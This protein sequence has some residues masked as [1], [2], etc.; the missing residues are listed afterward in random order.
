MLETEV[1]ARTRRVSACAPRKRRHKSVPGGRSVPSFR[2][3]PFLKQK[4]PNFIPR[5][6]HITT[7]QS[8]MH[9]F[10]TGAAAVHERRQQPR[11]GSS[12]RREEDALFRTPCCSRINASVG[13]LLTTENFSVPSQML[14]K[15]CFAGGCCAGLSAPFCF[16]AVAGMMSHIW[17]VP[18]TS[19]IAHGINSHLCDP[20]STHAARRISTCTRAMSMP[21]SMAAV[22]GL[23]EELYALVHVARAHVLGSYPCMPVPRL[24]DGPLVLR[25]CCKQ[26]T[27]HHWRG[28]VG[29]HGF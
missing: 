11:S 16:L 14:Y 25:S 8:H 18:S 2:G 6:A 27:C 20:P 19:P 21:L 4:G 9:Y 12:P 7:S 15:L 3:H 1:G 13:Y 29:P 24:P 10:C 22:D 5:M 17:P 23:S 26:R 28:A